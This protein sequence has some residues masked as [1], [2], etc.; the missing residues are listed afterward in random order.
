VWQNFTVNPF[1]TEQHQITLHQNARK[2]GSALYGG[3][4]TECRFHWQFKN[5]TDRDLNSVIRFP[6]PAATAMYDNLSAVL[7]GKD[8][9]PQMHLREAT[10]ALNRDLK[11]HEPLDLTISFKSRGMSF[12][13]FQVKEPREVRNFLL[14]MTLPDLGKARLNYPEGCMTP[15]SIQPT[16]DNQGSV[17]TY[18]LDHAI[19][20]KGMGISLPPLPQPGATTSAV[21]NEI[22]RGWLLIFASLIL[23]FTLTQTNYSVLLIVLFGAATACG[24]G[25]L[26]DFSD[27]LFGFWGTAALVFVPFLCLV[28]AFLK[29]FVPERIWRVL[30][31]ELMVF[32]VIYPSIAGLDSDRQTLYFNVAAVVFLALAAF[33]LACRLGGSDA[34]AKR[35]DP[36]TAPNLDAALT[37]P[38]PSSA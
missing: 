38:S 8:V 7:N 24:Y 35:P 27:L 28:T 34:A 13:Y 9:L 23:G 32:G 22:E 29:K 33:Q 26:A 16:T 37:D 4:E 10:L 5:P 12:W 14:T 25:L 2:K 31:V 20:S 6:L 11:A 36:K 30:A 17:L 15:T 18:R 19:S 3:Y 21:L 1:I